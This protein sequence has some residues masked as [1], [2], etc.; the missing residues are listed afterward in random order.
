MPRGMLGI[1]FLEKNLD[2]TFSELHYIYLN[3]TCAQY[4]YLKIYFQKILN[5]TIKRD[6]L[7]RNVN[8]WIGLCENQ[9]Y[10]KVSF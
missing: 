4:F 6:N 5:G 3:L 10:N 9:I 7:Y 2:E 8:K 1:L